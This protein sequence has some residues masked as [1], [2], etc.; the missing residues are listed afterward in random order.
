MVA[1]NSCKVMLI[2][3][4]D[5]RSSVFHYILGCISPFV[6]AFVII[7]F[8]LLYETITWKIKQEKITFFIG[9]LCEFSLGLLTG[10]LLLLL[11]HLL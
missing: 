5:D 1:E 6:F 2:E 4:F 8:Y 10:Y 11:S 9:D 3:I 7:V